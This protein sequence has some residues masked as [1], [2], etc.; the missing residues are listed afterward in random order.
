MKFDLESYSEWR[1]AHPTQPLHRDVE[2]WMVLEIVQLREG[3]DLLQQE[4]RIRQNLCDGFAAEVEQLRAEVA[5][6]RASVPPLHP[7]DYGHEVWT[8]ALREA[9]EAERA[10]AVAYL[11]DEATKPF[12][13][14]MALL[15]AAKRVA[16]GEHR[17]EGDK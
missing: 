16:R 2:S 15:Y 4:A 5:F 6:L 10:D 8:N 3:V 1:H 17:R 11:R 12:E 14:G 9:V 13:G 7:R